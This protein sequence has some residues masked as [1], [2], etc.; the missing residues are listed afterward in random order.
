MLDTLESEKPSPK[1]AARIRNLLE[2]LGQQNE[3]LQAR[4]E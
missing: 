3:K 2:R 1:E 4:F